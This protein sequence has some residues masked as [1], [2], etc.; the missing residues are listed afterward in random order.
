MNTECVRE[1]FIVTI[2]CI[3]TTDEGVSLGSKIFRGI[4]TIFVFLL[5]LANVVLSFVYLIYWVYDQ[6][7]ARKEVEEMND[8]HVEKVPVIEIPKKSPPGI[9]TTFA[10]E[11]ERRVIIPKTEELLPKNGGIVQEMDNDGK[12]NVD[13]IPE[14]SASAPEPLDS[15]VLYPI[16]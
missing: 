5:F 15:H 11:K 10:E 14:F 13:Y 16:L 9:M 8:T 3:T 7:K 6:W 1:F 2:S 12:A 4:L